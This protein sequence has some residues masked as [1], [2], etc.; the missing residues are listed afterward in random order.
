MRRVMVG[1]GPVGGSSFAARELFHNCLG[2]AFA[3][4]KLAPPTSKAPPTVKKTLDEDI[5]EFF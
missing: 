1:I 3:A 4:S 5:N 2:Q